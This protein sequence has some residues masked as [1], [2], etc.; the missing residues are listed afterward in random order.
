MNKE[1]FLK[2]ID[3]F[4]KNIDEHMNEDISIIGCA[5]IVSS[6]S[7]IIDFWYGNPESLVGSLE[8]VKEIIKKD[9]LN[10]VSSIAYAN[11]K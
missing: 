11:K 8:I 7:G 5:F 10:N 9:T 3:N 6:N 2:T 1:E 4:K